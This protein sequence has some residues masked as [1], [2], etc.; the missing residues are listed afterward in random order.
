MAQTELRSERGIRSD[1]C[2]APIHSAASCRGEKEGAVDLSQKLV[3][4][5]DEIDHAPGNG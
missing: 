2:S 4:S 3:P 5:I 1:I